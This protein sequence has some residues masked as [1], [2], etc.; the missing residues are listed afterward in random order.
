MAHRNGEIHCGRPH[1]AVGVW[2]LDWGDDV[3]NPFISAKFPEEI[4][5]LAILL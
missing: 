2:R 5:K 1:I 3:N 4:D